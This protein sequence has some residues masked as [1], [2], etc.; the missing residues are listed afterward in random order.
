LL[1]TTKAKQT[2]TLPKPRRPLNFIHGSAR[3]VKFNRARDNSSISADVFPQ[4]YVFNL[5]DTKLEVRKESAVVFVDR[6][7]AANWG[8]P[9][10]Y[11]FFDP[12]TG[13][14]LY[15]ED[16]L[17]P[18][19]LAGARSMEVFHAPPVVSTKAAHLTIPPSAF[20]LLVPLPPQPIVSSAAQQRYAILWTSQISDLRHV[21]DLEFMW[22]TLVNVYGFSAANIFVLCYNG[23]IGAVNVT[24]AVGNWAGNN[25]PYQMKV[26]ASATVANLQ[27]VINTLAGKLEPKDLLLVHTQSRR[28]DWNLRGRFQRNHADAV[29]QH[30]RW[31]SRVPQPRRHDGTMLLGR[32]P[33]ARVAKEHCHEH[34]LCLC[35]PS[36]PGVR[37]SG[38][39]RSLGAGPDR[40][41][42]RRDPGGRGAARQADVKL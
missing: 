33:G 34:S 26:Y 5:V 36:E 16:A 21:E 12:S 4:G 3:F 32:I 31:P 18:P 11:R 41:T 7:P 19:N 37:R 8:H 40:G 27:A 9:C 6:R 2:T 10:T 20:E 23:T 42:E 29:R 38:A 14:F 15:E 28:S 25:T 30:D 35:G 39:L 13:T 24:G 1:L 17:F 22:R